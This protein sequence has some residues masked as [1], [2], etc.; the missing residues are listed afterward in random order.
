MYTYYNICHDIPRIPRLS[1]SSLYTLPLLLPLLLSFGRFVLG[2][3]LAGLH[4][5][6]ELGFSYG[7]LKPENILITQLGHIKVRTIGML[8][9]N[10][11]L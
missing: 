9:L 6:H 11:C 10:P 3:V 8:C 4:Y 2:E 5:I 7:D 1:T